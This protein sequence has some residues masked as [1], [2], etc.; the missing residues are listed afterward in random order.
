MYYDR[1]GVIKKT[2]IVNFTVTK[3]FTIATN[4]MFP[5]YL[6]FVFFKITKKNLVVFNKKTHVYSTVQ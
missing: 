4:V 6:F 5:W 3:S 2:T 1:L